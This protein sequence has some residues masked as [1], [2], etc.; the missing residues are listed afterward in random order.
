[1]RSAGKCMVEYD[2]LMQEARLS[3][4]EHIRRIDD[5]RQICAC[6]SSIMEQPSSA[7]TDASLRFIAGTLISNDVPAVLWTLHPR[8]HHIIA[9]RHKDV[10]PNLEVLF[11]IDPSL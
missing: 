11:H 2:D 8:L 1:M 10:L 7:D 4:L 5:K 9:S 3:F 6:R